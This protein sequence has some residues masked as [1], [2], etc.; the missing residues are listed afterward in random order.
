[1][2]LSG[3]FHDWYSPSAQFYN[4]DGVKYHGGDAIWEWMR[5]LFGQFEKLQ[6]EMKITRILPY[7]TEAESENGKTGELV[8]FDCVT[9]FWI[10]GQLKGEGISVPRMLSFLVGESEEDGQGTDGL[11]ILEAK[12]WWDST[13][14]G[15]EIARRKGELK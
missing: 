8:M 13:V 4:A 12:T 9:T 1:V 14:L 7:V 3:P 6:H 2:D 5:S 15:R 11:Q 10:G